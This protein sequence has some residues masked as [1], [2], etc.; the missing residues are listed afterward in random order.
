M[1][2]RDQLPRHVD[3]KRLAIYDSV[4]VTLRSQ[5]VAIDL[6]NPS[7]VTLAKLPRQ[8]YGRGGSDSTHRN[9]AFSK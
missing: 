1:S 8:I 5:D 4:D 9:S 2:T 6:V 3:L 7:Q